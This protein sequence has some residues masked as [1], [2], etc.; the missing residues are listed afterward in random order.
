MANRK[1]TVKHERRDLAHVTVYT[2]DRDADEMADV[3]AG[4]IDRGEWHTLTGATLTD[5]ER[6]EAMAAYKAGR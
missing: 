5:A 2:W 4:S 1:I 3:Y 6:A